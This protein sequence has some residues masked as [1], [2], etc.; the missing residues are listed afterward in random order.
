MRIKPVLIPIVLIG[1]FFC[2]SCKK[3]GVNLEYTNAKGEVPTLGNL[4]FRFSKALIPDSLLNQ[5]DST[6]YVSFEPKISGK[7]RWESSDQLVFSPSTPLLPATTYKA[8]VKTAVLHFSKYNSVTNADKINFHT[9]QLTLDNS[10]VLWVPLDDGG[11][12]AV[13]QVDLFFN[14]RVNPADIKDKL[15]IELEGNK[16]DYTLI[17]QSPDNKISIRFADFKSEDKDYDAKLTIEK[18]LKPEVGTDATVEPIVS[19]FSIPS[20]F[21][22]SVQNMQAEHDGVEGT[23]TITTSQQVVNE[24][25]KSFIKFEP[26]IAFTT[27]VT[28]NGFII[29]SEKFDVEKS[30][31]LTI[32]KKP[33]WPYWRCIKRG[34]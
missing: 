3:N 1:I 9:P 32:A 20:A 30:Y 22:L 25:L 5:W 19:S 17:T 18:G 29:R 16:A 28:D 13:P 8:K 6:D 26:A 11:K 27:E 21:N 24:E 23:V 12:K 7:F 10:Q 31:A 15:K 14:Y 34:V 4:V 33:T 2:T